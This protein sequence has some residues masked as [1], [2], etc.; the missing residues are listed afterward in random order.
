MDSPRIEPRLI[1]KVGGAALLLFLALGVHAL[2][3]PP[4]GSIAA[5]WPMDAVAGATTPDVSGNGN[6]ATLVGGPLPVAGLAGN[7]L[8]FSGSSQYLTAANSAS[9]DVGAG[10]FSVAAW[11]NPATTNPGRVVNKWD[12]AKGWIFDVNTTTGGAGA[13]GF[14]RA[15]MND[16][17]TTIDYSI[18]GPVATAAWQHIAVTVDRTAKQ[19]KLFRSGIQVGTTQDISALAGSLTTT[20]LVGMGTIPATPGNFYNG[21]LDE[22]IFYKR[23]LTGPEL[24]SLATMPPPAPAGLG[25]VNGT[26]QVALNWSASAGAASYTVLRSGT[27]GG[28]AT[29]P[30][31]AIASG[32]AGVTYTDTTAVNPNT[33]YY[34]VQAVAG[35]TPSAN[36]TETIGNPLPTPVT[37]APNTGLFTNENGATTTFSIFFNQPA[38]AAGSMVTVTSNNPAEGKVSSATNPIPATS[39]VINVAAGFSSY[40]PITVTGIDD[41]IADGPQAFTISVTATN[42]TGPAIPNVSCTNNDNDTPGITFSRLSGV[43]TTEGGGQATF[44]VSL[45]TQPFGTITMSLASSNTLEGTVSPASLT[46][47]PAAGPNAWNAAHLVTVTG[48]DDT[49]LDF[50]IAYTIVTGTLGISDV[51]DNAGYNF[52]PPDV[53]CANI[54]DE[55]IPSLPHVWGG[56]GGGGGGCGLLG[57]EAGLALLLA[58]LRRRR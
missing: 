48:V 46:F 32:V 16:G 3:S 47:T 19:L 38:P 26:N 58:A 12:G 6:A 13:A 14:V 54:D 17:T 18:A 43:T 53:Q 11:V 49:V 35:S 21:S 31:V 10:S 36:S 27:S 2:Q 52:D 9:L 57:L 42:I 23:V 41:F 55:Q 34:V 8:Q 20:S 44:T 56:S 39:I 22:V 5:Q 4:A 33:Y 28:P 37:A 40:I 29:D 50:T 7:G 24:V 1:R 30:Y 15:K 25:H 51:R 45:N